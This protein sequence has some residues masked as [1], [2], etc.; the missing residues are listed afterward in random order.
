[1]RLLIASNNRGK[2]R[3]YRDIL[4]DLPLELVTPADIGLELEVAEAGA[5][6]YENALLKARAFA[7][8]SGL[9]T[10]ADDSGLEV[11]ALGGEPGMHS[12]RY[13]SGGDSDRY[14][15]LL[16]RLQG[17][18]PKKRTAR[19][20]CVIVIVDPG[21]GTYTCEGV[22]PGLILSAPRGEG[23][24]GYDPVFLLPDLG[25]TMAELAA[26]EKNRLSHRARA[27]QCARPV[28]LSLLARE[29]QS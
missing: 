27:G 10:L 3:E 5:S 18:P 24:F 21:G 4:G 22:C 19:F 7:R 16:E 12:H 17:V 28:L 29:T 11:D 9:L 23:G 14:R 1:V 26:E 8:A 20:R 2:L 13:A 6:Y 15:A 25:Q